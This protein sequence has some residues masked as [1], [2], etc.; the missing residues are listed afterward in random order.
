MTENKEDLSAH[1]KA[2][3]KSIDNKITE[4]EEMRKNGVKAQRQQELLS[5][6]FRRQRTLGKLKKGKN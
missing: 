6:I 4:L 2:M 5:D 1:I 3:Q